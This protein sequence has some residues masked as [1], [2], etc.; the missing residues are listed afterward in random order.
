MISIKTKEVRDV[1][2]LAEDMN[3]ISLLE[4]EYSKITKLVRACKALT[5]RFEGEQ[6]IAITRFVSTKSEAIMY[7]YNK[8]QSV[9]AGLIILE[10]RKIDL[11]CINELVIGIKK[12]Y[13]IETD[14][15]AIAKIKLIIDTFII[16]RK[17][18]GVDKECWS[19]FYRVFY[20]GKDNTLGWPTNKCIAIQNHVDETKLIHDADM[21]T[22]AKEKTM[23]DDDFG[24]FSIDE[25]IEISE[26]VDVVEKEKPKSFFED[27]IGKA[28][29]NRFVDKNHDYTLDYRSN[30]VPS[31]SSIK[32]V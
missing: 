10:N 4:T 15:L 24:M 16:N 28:K 5:K 25:M 27:I 30:K 6:S 12:A 18:I 20:P 11:K 3:D 31:P 2:G 9:E 32:N 23:G 17:T 8:I 21:A 14:K 29:I 1:I 13:S 22:E 26:K 19:S 7:Y